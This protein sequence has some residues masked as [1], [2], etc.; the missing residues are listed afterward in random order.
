MGS[1]NAHKCAEYAEKDF[2]LTLFERYHKDGD[3]F[4][5]HI[6]YVTGDEA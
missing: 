5:N 6:A 3:G 4:L 1:E 2:G